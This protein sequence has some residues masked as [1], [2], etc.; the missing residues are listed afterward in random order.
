[1]DSGRPQGGGRE[2]DCRALNL[3]VRWRNNLIFH[4]ASS[5]CVFCVFF[6]YFSSFDLCTDGTLGFP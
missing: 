5:S 6:F 1:M 4:Y 2:T 3:G